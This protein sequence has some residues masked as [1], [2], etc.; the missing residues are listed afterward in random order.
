MKSGLMVSVV[1]VVV[2]VVVVRWVAMN[3]VG[4]ICK[5]TRRPKCSDY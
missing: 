3:M 1:V 2:V 5:A 4:G